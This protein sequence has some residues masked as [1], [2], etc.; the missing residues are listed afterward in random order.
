M[1]LFFTDE[2]EKKVYD[3]LNSLELAGNPDIVLID[4]RNDNK[5]SASVVKI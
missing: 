3:I 2:E 4:A 1:I 5:P